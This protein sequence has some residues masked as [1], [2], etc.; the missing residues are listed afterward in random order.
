[1]AKELGIRVADR[2]AGLAKVRMPSSG[3]EITHSRTRNLS[4]KDCLVLQVTCVKYWGVALVAVV[5]AVWM[6]PERMRAQEPLPSPAG[7]VA[8]NSRCFVCHINY[9][10]EEL[11][12]RHAQANIGCEKC[13]GRSSAHCADEDNVT[14]PDIMYPPEKIAAFCITCH[15]TDK[16]GKPRKPASAESATKPRYCTDCHGKH[17]LSYRTRHWDKTT[18]KLLPRKQGG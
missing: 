10:K 7:S 15:P 6:C 4:R 12:S 18:G 16:S 3:N 11:A 13:H 5:A 1:M 9:K 14:P 2:V 17:R 8:D